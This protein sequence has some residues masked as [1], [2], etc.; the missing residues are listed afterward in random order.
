VDLPGEAAAP[1][2]LPGYIVSLARFHERGFDVLAGR[3]D[4]IYSF[5]TFGAISM[6]HEGN[7]Y[8]VEILG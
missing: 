5:E 8:T 2:P 7:R 6:D 4:E 3:L 1:K